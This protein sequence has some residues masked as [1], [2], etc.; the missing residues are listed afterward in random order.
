VTYAALNRNPPHAVSLDGLWTFQHE[1]DTAPRQAHVPLPWQAEFPDLRLESGKATYSRSFQ[2]PQAWAGLDIFLHFGAVSYYA[3]VSLN[4][5]DLGDHEGGYLPFEFRLPENILKENNDLTVSVTLPNGNGNATPDFPFAEIPHGKQSWYGPLGGLWQ[6]VHLLARH[7]QHL[8][9]CRITA[10]WKTATTTLSLRHSQAATGTTLIVTLTDPNGKQV[11]ETRQ[12]VSGTATTISLPVEN[13]RA[14]SPDDPQLYT[15]TISLYDD[16]QLCDQTVHTF[17]FRHFES[18]DGR[19]FLNGQAFYMRGALDQDYY[20]EGICTPPSLAFL[21]DQ[22]VKAKELGLNLLRCHIKIPDPRYYEVADRLG[23]LIWTEIPNVATFT[24]ASARRMRE[25]MEGILER[26]FNHPSIVIWTIINEDWGTRLR[27][28]QTHRDWL[29]ATY[30]WLKALDP[31]RLVVDNSACHGNFHVKT[32]INDFHYYRSVPQRRAE[33]DKL[34]QE[35]ANKPDWAWSPFGDAVR[36]DNEPL[37]VSE[38]GVWGLPDPKKL[39]KADGSEPWWMETGPGWGDGAAYPHGVETRFSTYR[40]GSTFGTFG[41]FIAKVQDYQFNNLKYE[42][43]TMRAANPIQGY[44]ITEL[45]D[46]HWEANGL[47]DIDRNPRNF[48]HQ[49]ATINTDIV[50]VPKVEHYAGTTG[51]QLTIGLA[52]ASGGKDIGSPSRLLWQLEGGESGEI[53]VPALSASSV[54]D[55]PGL[56]IRFPDMDMAKMLTLAFR[57]VE[58]QTE[59][60][61]NEITIAVY[62]SRDTRALPKI[63]TNNPAL[64]D[65]ARGLGYR[66]VE[67]DQAD[68]H[69]V[70]ALDEQDIATM[71]AGARYLVLADGAV[72]T[73]GNLRTDPPKREQPFMPIV[74]EILGNIPGPEGQMPNIN[75]IARNNTMWRGD[76]IAGFSWIRRRDA[77]ANIPGGPL[78]DLSFD[79]VVP[80]HVMTGFRSFEYDGAVHAGVVL[81]WAHKP[82]AT[83]AERRVGRGGLVATTFRL[84]NDAPG[85]DPVA[86]ALFDALVRTLMD[87]PTE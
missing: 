67:R 87:M 73:H 46:V 9:H 68:L 86:S 82:A 79:R 81:G 70:H 28:D 42:I 21:E 6:S 37:V 18:R 85:K 55:L 66:V 23:M 50:I 62:P 20:P 7:P 52:I 56:Y 38:F 1:T 13:M 26:D 34:T 84:T 24:Q 3:K 33:W 74:D 36:N 12:T 40:L 80:Y 83:I 69:L 41:A 58:N 16:E 57:L 63:A 15:A 4:G 61:K 47:M 29:K 30:D 39:K 78:L 32:D 31:T 75:L 65:H 45:T 17:G 48:H 54:F 19:F 25:T 72:K 51:E 27:E 60:A 59:L 71:Q 14:W 5:H 11:A 10:D 76:W 44:V 53:T 2:V 77:F 35:F 8:S 43:E 64:A 22:L 49:F